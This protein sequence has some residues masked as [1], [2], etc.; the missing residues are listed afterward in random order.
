MKSISKKASHWARSRKCSFWFKEETTSTNAIARDEAFD[1]KYDFKI[2]LTCHQTQG[3]GRCTNS[4]EDTGNSFLSSWSYR[5]LHAPQPIMGPLVGLALFK[6]CQSVWPNLRWSLKAPNDLFLMDKKVAGLLV[7]SIQQG[8]EYRLII[9]LGIN[10]NNHPKSVETA[11]HIASEL[12][13]GVLLK[14]EVLYALFDQL[15]DQFERAVNQGTTSQISKEDRG[16]LLTALNANPLKTELFLEV[17]DQG[18]LVTESQ[19]LA[20]SSL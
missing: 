18:D 20:W 1:V 15:K 11:T 9:G 10:I 2:Y 14:E 5:V 7:E 8:R 13:T 16:V 19:T 17:T 6:A 3:R 12:G 4:W